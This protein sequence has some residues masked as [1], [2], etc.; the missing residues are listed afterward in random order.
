MTNSKNSNLVQLLSEAKDGKAKGVILS[1]ENKRLVSSEKK[2]LALQTTKG[3][4]WYSLG[5]LIS[6]E[7]NARGAKLLGK[8][9]LKELSIST[10]SPQRRS[11]A[12]IFFENYEQL[13]PLVKRF[14]NISALL[15]EFNKKNS[16]SSPSVSKETVETDSK[17]SEVS[18]D[19]DSNNEVVNVGTFQVP[20]VKQ[21]A[22]AIILQAIENGLEGSDLNAL[23]N[24]IAKQIKALA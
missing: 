8:Q 24:E 4:F 5:E 22:E 23:S 21:M 12:K 20:N 16:K 1:K 11:E 9:V 6:N 13:Q 14:G 15:K 3:G 10:I 17:E 7:L 19:G 18:D 2:Q